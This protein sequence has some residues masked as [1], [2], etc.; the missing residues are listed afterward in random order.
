MKKRNGFTLIELVIAMSLTSVFA[1]ILGTVVWNMVKVC[2]TEQE[3]T[4]LE[5]DARILQEQLSRELRDV[6]ASS[7]VTIGICGLVQ[8]TTK[9][10][11]GSEQTRHWYS[12]P[13]S[14]ELYEEP[15]ADCS[16]GTLLT[17]FYDSST[18]PLF[19]DGIFEWTISLTDD[20]DTIPV[21]IVVCPRNV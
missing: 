21:R 15:D 3:L 8:V 1:L 14:S 9:T 2:E 7:V 11:G 18:T 13:G 16:D 12:P 6:K 5:Q 17:N 20:T 10:M 4:R 19:S